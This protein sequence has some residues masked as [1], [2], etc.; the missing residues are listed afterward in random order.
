MRRNEAKNL[1]KIKHI[2]VS[3][4]ANDA[5]FQRRFAQYGPQKGAFC[6]KRSGALELNGGASRGGSRTAPTLR[7][8]GV[9]PAV[10]CASANPSQFSPRVVS[11][12]PLIW[13][14]VRCVHKLQG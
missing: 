9:S 8:A 5:R 14:E 13:E 11:S 1:L 3:K 12:S 4:A 7:G 6:A 2:T 10:A